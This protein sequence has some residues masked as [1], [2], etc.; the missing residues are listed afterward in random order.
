MT[1]RDKLRSQVGRL[2][3]LA[4]RSGENE[5]RDGRRD[6]RNVDLVLAA[7]LQ[8]PEVLK[9]I[10]YPLAYVDFLRTCIEPVSH[11]V[12][13]VK[14]DSSERDQAANR[15]QTLL[16]QLQGDLPA[17]EF[18][19]AREIASLVDQGLTNSE[20]FVLRQWA[21]DVGLHLL[22]SSSF[23]NKGRIL[24]NI[25]RFMRSKCCLELG[26]AYGMSALFI[27]G[28]LRTYAKPGYLATVE[29]MEPQFSLGSSMLKSRH[30][31]SVE[32]R[33]GHTA[34][35]LPEL[36]KSL[37]SIDFMFHDCGHSREDYIRDF[38]LVCDALAP[39]AVVM[40]DDIRWMPPRD[41]LEG[42]PHT[43]DGWKEV[44]A[45]PRVRRAVEIDSMF[46]MFLMR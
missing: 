17:I 44:I 13:V 3:R 16:D 6:Q 45:H 38:S 23:G 29:S 24:F 14:E 19:V 25:V 5:L 37:G 33:F 26:T 11:S 22:I 34:H 46:G 31:E 8:E 40:F 41:L 27:L 1:I 30:G 15:F 10:Q 42:D 43:Y 36:A 20:V 2:A 7:V 4:A 32:C 18:S 35:V 21:L 9:G 39:G 12:E 28:A